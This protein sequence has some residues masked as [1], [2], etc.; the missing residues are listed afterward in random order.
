MS[1]TQALGREPKTEAVILLRLFSGMVLLK[2]LSEVNSRE[3][4]G[5]ALEKRLRIGA[6]QTS[7]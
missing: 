7:D 3:G 4:F 2:D 6:T 5:L 1:V